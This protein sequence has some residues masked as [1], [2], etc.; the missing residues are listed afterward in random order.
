MLKIFLK[1]NNKK[2]EPPQQRPGEGTEGDGAGEGTLRER[3]GL[4]RL[5]V[6]LGPQASRLITSLRPLEAL[7]RS[8]TGELEPGSL[9]RGWSGELLQVTGHRPRL[10]ALGA[11]AGL[12]LSLRRLA[13]GCQA[14]SPGCRGNIRRPEA[15]R[16]QSRSGNAAPRAPPNLLPHSLFPQLLPRRIVGGRGAGAGE[17]PGKASSTDFQQGAASAYLGDSAKNGGN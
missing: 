17:S 13:G 8:G 15:P 16:G 6:L 9:W 10:G 11:G 4:D 7:V 5:L 3:R 1:A 2:T 14:E 12:P